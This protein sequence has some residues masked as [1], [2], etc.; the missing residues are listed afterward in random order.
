MIL[1]PWVRSLRVFFNFYFSHRWSVQ[2]RLRVVDHGRG[3]WTGGQDQGLQSD[4]VP[5]SASEAQNITRE[6]GGGEE[7]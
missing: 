5:A 2:Q 6:T 7:G 3:R 1:N 4:H